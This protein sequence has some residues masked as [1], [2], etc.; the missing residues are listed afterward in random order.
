VLVR[1]RYAAGGRGQ[2]VGYSVAVRPGRGGR[3]VWY[4]GGRLA[5][6]LTLPRLRSSWLETSPAEAIATWQGRSSVPGREARVLRAEAWAQACAQVDAAAELLAGVPLDDHAT[7]TGAAREAAGIFAALA[8]RSDMPYKSELERASDSL[9]R[10]ALSRRGQAR[11]T[12]TSEA[13]SA[14]RGVQMVAIQAGRVGRSPRGEAALIAS[15]MGTAAAIERSHALRGE[16]QQAARLTSITQGQLAT[17][18]A[19]R[20]ARPAQTSPSPGQVPHRP[21]GQRLGPDRGFER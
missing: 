14:Y 8:A 4:G 20:A 9:A 15:M 19:A 2:V 5:S 1:P 6:D 7:W 13:V 11:A 16:A 18:H 17:L 10:S 12:R 21:P 3:P